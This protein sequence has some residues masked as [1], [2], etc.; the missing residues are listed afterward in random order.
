MLRIDMAQEPAPS[1]YKIQKNQLKT[2]I[3]V[4]RLFLPL[5]YFNNNEILL[6][7]DNLMI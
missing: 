6:K 1:L 2:L 7:L 5:N 3:I 4:I